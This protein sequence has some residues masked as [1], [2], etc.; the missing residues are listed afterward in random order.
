V[1]KKAR[2][3]GN[4]VAY[5]FMMIDDNMYKMYIMFNGRLPDLTA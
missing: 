3:Y 1:N 5:Y 2:N 4:D